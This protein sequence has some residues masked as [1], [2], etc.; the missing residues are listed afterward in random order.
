MT[1]SL[2]ISPCPNDT[3]L[4]EPLLHGRVD[5]EGLSFDVQH[6]D[7]AELNALARLGTPDV[8]KLSFFTYFLVQADYHLLDAGAALGRGCGPLLVGRRPMTRTELASARIAI[9]GRDTTAHLL[10]EH[11][12]PE[13]RERV[14]MLF[15][16]IM[17]AVASGEVD[18]GV[19]IHESRFTYPQH[20]LHLMQDLGEYWESQ[21][22]L[23]IPL[24]GIAVHRR[25]GQDITA[26][27]ERSLRRSAEFA[28]SHPEAPMPYVR[29]HAQEMDDAVM[30]AHI[31]LYVNDYSVSLGADGRAAIA[32]LGRYAERLTALA[33]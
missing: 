6:A 10:L 12:A 15:S 33:G 19:I 1:L 14:P 23:P 2:A 9:P 21:T 26:S 25:L 30:R 5:A 20:S 18:A 16:A 29:Q 11:Y 32:H 7:I 13:A 22:G 31:A 17:P 4:F 3:F 8:V 24:G 28:L 27:V